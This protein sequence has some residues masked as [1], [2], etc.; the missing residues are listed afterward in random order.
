MIEEKGGQKPTEQALSSLGSLE[1]SHAR[2][3]RGLESS[4]EHG[5]E[6]FL[7]TISSI[8]VSLLV[9]RV[10]NTSVLTVHRL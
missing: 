4:Q 5:P 9:W 1:L 8:S 3:L 7:E 2:I 6:L 10:D